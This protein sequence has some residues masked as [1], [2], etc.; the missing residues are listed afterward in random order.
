MKS[1]RPIDSEL[2]NFIIQATLKFKYFQN[3]A[4]TIVLHPA[5]LSLNISRIFEQYF[6]LSHSN[7]LIRIAFNWYVTACNL[8]APIEVLIMKFLIMKFHI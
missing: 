3:R 7:V 6:E 4:Q 1:Y 2:W 8:Q 5:V